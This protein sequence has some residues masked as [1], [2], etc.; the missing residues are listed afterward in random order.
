MSRM[1]LKLLEKDAEMREKDERHARHAQILLENWRRAEAELSRLDDAM[2]R[3]VLVS[4]S[5]FRFS[6]YSSS[7][8]EQFFIR[9]RASREL[10]TLL[11]CRRC[12]ASRK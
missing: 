12:K 2:D 9:Q 7:V 10:L 8:L 3:V 11:C 4:D 1:R 6:T 5:L